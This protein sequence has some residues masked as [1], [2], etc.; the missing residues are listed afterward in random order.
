VRATK[1]AARAILERLIELVKIG[2]IEPQPTSA[3]AFDQ[4]PKILSD[5]LHRRAIGKPVIVLQA[6]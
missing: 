3:H 2:K 4:A 1:G 6:L 5:I